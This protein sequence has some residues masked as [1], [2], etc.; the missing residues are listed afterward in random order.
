MNLDKNIEEI[1]AGF[2]HLKFMVHLGAAGSAPLELHWFN[3]IQEFWS[4]RLN[5]SNLGGTGHSFFPGGM[6]G[7]AKVEAAKLINAKE[8]EICWASRVVEGIN[9]SIDI[10]G[11]NNPWKKGD[12]VVF[13]DQGYP[14]SGHSFLSLRKMGV[15]LRQIKHS[16]GKVLLYGGPKL[17]KEIAPGVKQYGD[18]DQAVDERTKLVCIDRTTW[19]LGF[20]IDVEAVCKLAH[21]KGALVVDDAFQSIGAIKVDV[22]KENLDFLITGSYKWQCGP[23]EAGIFYVKEDLIEKLDP[24]HYQY[25]NVQKPPGAFFG[26]PN[27]DNIKTYDLPLVKSATKFDD[28]TI[29][30][31][32]LWGWHATLKYLNELGAE[33]IQARDRALATY[34]IEKV[35]DI[36]CTVKTPLDDKTTLDNLHLLNYT[37]GSDANDRKSCEELNKHLPIPIAGPTMRYQGYIGGIRICTQFYNTEED[38]DTFIEAQKT[39]MPS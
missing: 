16:D 2:P 33:N 12:N 20:T 38:I 27:H 3:A 19:H 11:Y 24:P 14:S 36:G 5:G 8:K 29:A 10:V 6:A 21:E 26:D 22:H 1:R 25:I 17:G 9:K 34:L 13:D 39:L 15:E 7:K 18:M 30:M 32:M 31:D 4:H 28:W 37:T 35:Q 23:P